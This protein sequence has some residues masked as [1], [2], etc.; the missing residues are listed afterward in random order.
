MNVYK[1]TLLSAAGATTARANQQQKSK[2]IAA[3][4]REQVRGESMRNKNGMR[5]KPSSTLCAF[6]Q[7]TSAS[8]V[9]QPCRRD[10][11]GDDRQQCESISVAISNSIV[12]LH[13]AA[14]VVVVLLVLFLL[15]LRIVLVFFF[16]RSE[17]C[18]TAED[19]QFE[20][21]IRGRYT[22]GI[23]PQLCSAV[24]A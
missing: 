19:Y 14:V 12:H 16:V 7:C 21:S 6:A 5:A 13:G 11:I 1:A 22:A 20:I 17:R 10:I 24:P 23:E 15:Y 3:T 18:A 8:G 9:Q 4:R 2:Q